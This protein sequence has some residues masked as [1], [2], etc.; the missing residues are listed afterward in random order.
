MK[1]IEGRLCS[2]FLSVLL[3][4]T[5]T[6]FVIYTTP[7]IKLLTTCFE[8]ALCQ[9]YSIK[10]FKN[11]NDC[12]W[13]SCNQSCTTIL[14]YCKQI[15]V[16]YKLLI[17]NKTDYVPFYVNAVNCGFESPDLCDEFYRNYFKLNDVAFD[18][19]VSCSDYSYAIPYYA[20]DSKLYTLKN[21]FISLIPLILFFVSFL[22]IKKRKLFKLKVK[23][24]KNK[25]IN[26]VKHLT[27]YE[28]KLVEM[29][30]RKRK[31][32]LKSNIVSAEDNIQVYSVKPKR[33]CWLEDTD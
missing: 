13:T 29:D 21:L 20:N 27:F 12:S 18:C 14:Y 3:L 9:T 23:K 15:L 5:V 24:M 19:L 11:I 1:D 16:E 6:S 4:S 31:S 2:I 28:K 33:N 25:S 8:K 26:A 17:N 30:S 22:Y 7:A 32:I 10:S